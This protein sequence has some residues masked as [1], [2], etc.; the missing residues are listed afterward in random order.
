[1]RIVRYR[2]VQN[3]LGEA[4]VV[5]TGVQLPPAGAA[6]FTVDAYGRIFI[7]VPSSDP[8]T[9]SSGVVLG[10]DADGGA[11]QQNRSA[12]PIVA[13]APSVPVAIGW[14]E[15]AQQLWVTGSDAGRPAIVR[16][17]VSP[18]R[19]AD[20]W[21]RIPESVQLEGVAP[22][23]RTASQQP[24]TG[25]SLLL[26]LSAGGRLIRVDA[27]ATTVE[28]LPALEAGELVATTMDART[29]AAYLAVRSPRGLRAYLFR[30][31]K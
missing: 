8:D 15:T 19:T 13:R 26:R 12:S 2:E 29:N 22:V 31:E 10:F 3:T 30:I 7:A 14:D 20:V 25:T 5:V 18:L 1:M 27:G 9:A 28:E 17:P 11:L 23:F 6:A 24:I 4:A 16:I 21:P